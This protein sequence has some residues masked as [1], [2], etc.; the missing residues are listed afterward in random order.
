[1]N[2]KLFIAFLYSTKSKMYFIEIKQQDIVVYIY[3][4][5]FSTFWCPAPSPR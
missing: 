1:M 2:V 3:T 4:I 5:N